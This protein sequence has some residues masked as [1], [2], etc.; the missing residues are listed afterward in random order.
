MVT[1]RKEASGIY[2]HNLKIIHRHN[3]LDSLYEVNWMS[4]LHLVTKLQITAW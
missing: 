3:L 2:L 4:K 1:Y